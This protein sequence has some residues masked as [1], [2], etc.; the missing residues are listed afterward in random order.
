[1]FTSKIHTCSSVHHT[2]DAVHS[3]SPPVWGLMAPVKDRAIAILREYHRAEAEPVDRGVLLT[4]G[5][6]GTV[7]GVTLEEV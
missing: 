2:P 6:V 5:K 3:I 1:V 7:A 4:D